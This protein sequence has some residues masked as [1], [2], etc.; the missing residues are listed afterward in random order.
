MERDFELSGEDIEYLESRERDWETIKE[1]EN[2]WAII[3]R[4]A[5]P[6]GYNHTETSVALLLPAAYPDVQIDMAYFHPALA[7]ADAKAIRNLSDQPLDGKTW[8]RWS[9]HRPADAWRPGVDN[10][11]THLLYVTAFLESELQKT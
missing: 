1:G 2:R 3:H 6:G 5:V 10:I 8:Q 7:R 9:R 11:E 4:F